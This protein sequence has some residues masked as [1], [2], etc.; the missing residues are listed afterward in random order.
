LPGAAQVSFEV[1]WKLMAEH[2]IHLPRQQQIVHSGHQTQALLMAQPWSLKA[3]VDVGSRPMA[4]HGTRSEQPDSFELRAAS[5]ELKQ[6]LLGLFGN[7]GDPAW[8]RC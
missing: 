5:Q 6:V 3:E 1:V 7:P 4:T 2:Q 8:I